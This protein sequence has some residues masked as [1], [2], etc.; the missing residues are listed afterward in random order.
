MHIEG[1]F[2]KAY[3]TYGVSK[4]YTTQANTYSNPHKYDIERLLRKKLSKNN[5]W[6][7]K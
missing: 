7:N 6:I 5:L 4:F 1:G 3:T 2:S